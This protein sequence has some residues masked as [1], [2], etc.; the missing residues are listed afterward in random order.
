MTKEHRRVVLV[1]SLVALVAL[2]L[3][4]FQYFASNRWFV[5]RPFPLQE[6]NRLFDVGVA[7]VNGDGWLD[8][9]T[10]NHHFRQTLLIADGK[11]DY[12]DVLSIWGL[13]QS[14]EFPQAELAFAAPEMAQA[15]VYIYWYG[16]NLVI[17]SH[18]ANEVGQWKGSLRVNDPIK[19]VKS[20]GFWVR[21]QQQTSGTSETLIEFSPQ[22]DGQLILTPGGQGL[23]ITFG[24]LDGITSTRIFVGRGKVSPPTTSFVLAMQD[25]HGMAW[26][27][28]NGDG[29]L[30]VFISRGAIAGNLLAYPESI[31]R[32]IK[33]ELLVSQHNEKYS[34]ITVEA[35]I[36][37]SGCSGRH[38]QWLDLDG[39]GLLDLFV[40]CYN[41]E[42][43]PGEY[44]KQ[45]Y[46]QNPRLHFRNVAKE[47][48]L[49]IPDQ[50]I[51]SF[52]WIDVDNDGTRDLVTFQDE[53]F[54]LYRNRDGYFVQETVQR[55]PLG[56]ADKIGHTEGSEWFF[57]GKMVVADF[58]RD[59]Y[60]D[61]FSAS[62]RGNALLVN[63]GG[64][65]SVVEPASAGLP[66]RSQTADWVDYDNDG[67]VDLFLFP[68]G[69][70]RQRP[71]HTFER[72]GLLAFNPDEYRAALANWFDF[73]NDGRRDLLLA[74]D[75]NPEFRHWWQ[76][77][78]DKKEGPKG[79]QIL[80]YRN[81]GASNHWLEARIDGAEG[82]RQAIGA[83]VSVTTRDGTQA[84]EVGNAGG[85]FFS[86][87]HYR[88]Y[89]GL[90]SYAQADSIVV[91]WPDGAERQLKN[92]AADRLI[93]VGRDINNEQ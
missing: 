1:V 72:T 65:F 23:P 14:R 85:A 89:F 57:D 56:G 59:G 42:N 3:G 5:L 90:G 83:R 78:Q 39:D 30:D 29:K 34:D 74:A 76:L 9:Y 22:G 53:G 16:S 11:G 13:D 61:V 79:W 20:D 60:L 26:A 48:G 31:R 71:D 63:S 19:V 51:G 17:R 67:L 2:V 58:N 86:Q 77:F 33:D 43:V 25:R 49:G 28:I 69:L 47:V 35:G 50:Q 52:A 75:R 41:R 24:F 55:R 70:Y 68:Q 36:E 10:S 4:I 84:Q 87:G 92:V 32:V 88:V 93:V 64:R 44:P 37:K 66:A 18:R 15:G 27:D 73:D 54:F 38:V 40:N 91:R 80:L 7:D 8:I 46:R 81:V 45:L 21:L 82:N 6:S 62:K 12:R